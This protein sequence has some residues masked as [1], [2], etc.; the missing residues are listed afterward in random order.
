MFRASR[1]LFWE[2]FRQT[3]L[4]VLLSLFILWGYITFQFIFD[5]MFYEEIFSSTIAWIIVFLTLCFLFL[6]TSKEGLTFAFPR[7]QFTLPVSTVALLNVHLVYRLFAMTLVGGMLYIIQYSFYFIEYQ[8]TEDALSLGAILTILLLITIWAQA[9]VCLLSVFSFWKTVGIQCVMLILVLGMSDFLGLL[10]GSSCLG[11]LNW[12]ISVDPYWERFSIVFYFVQGILIALP[13]WALA[14]AVIRK[15]FPSKSTNRLSL[16]LLLA[17]LSGKLPLYILLIPALFENLFHKML[18][19]SYSPMEIF[20]WYEEKTWGL[21]LVIMTGVIGYLGALW[22]L[23]QSRNRFAVHRAPSKPLF[24]QGVMSSK[25]QS[26]QWSPMRAQF[27][28]EWRQTYQWLPYIVI[29]TTI[30][31]L[32]IAFVPIEG[33]KDLTGITITWIGVAISW[34]VGFYGI[35][36]SVSYT[37]S[38]FTKPISITTMSRAKLWAGLSAVIPTFLLLVL[39]GKFILYRLLPE[40]FQETNVAYQSI[41]PSVVLMFLLMF[42]ALYLGRV[43]IVYLCGFYC[44]IAFIAM[45]THLINPF[46]FIDWEAT[47]IPVFL[48]M[49]LV[50]GIFLIFMT[51]CRKVVTSQHTLIT[52]GA[53]LCAMLLAVLTVYRNSC[54]SEYVFLNLFVLLSNTFAL[55]WVPLMLHRQRHR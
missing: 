32:L 50:L 33:T 2:L 30:V 8:N 18:S 45:L 24:K 14:V 27:W 46:L 40:T 16:F 48:I 10:T 51:W 13:F 47:C 17:L 6:S 42:G 3:W 52:I 20:V 39:A 4:V 28:Y 25:W 5:A 31:L 19:T 36:A 22:A 34:G 11:V 43:A 53:V 9:F 26:E 55:A 37:A 49:S 15:T 29:P 12:A 54:F 38:V 21:N 1:I 23:M 44:V 41:L 7:R 35:R